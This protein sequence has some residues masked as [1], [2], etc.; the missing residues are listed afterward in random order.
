MEVGEDAVPAGEGEYAPFAPGRRR[1]PPGGI[2][3]SREELADGAKQPKAASRQKRGT[4]AEK[5]PRWSAAG[6][7]VLRQRT[8]APQGA[9][10]MWRH[11]ALHPLGLLPRAEEREGGLPGAS[12]NTGDGACPQP[13]TPALSRPQL[14]GIPPQSA[15]PGRCFAATFLAWSAHFQVEV[16]RPLCGHPRRFRAPGRGIS[17]R[18]LYSNRG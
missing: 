9:M 7:S 16:K 10:L 17:P 5:T 12:K 3:T 11:A 18:Q 2:R 8:H 14:S 15:A 4:D 6:R 1:H 13:A